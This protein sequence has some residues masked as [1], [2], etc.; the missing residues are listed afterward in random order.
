MEPSYGA[1]MRLRLIACCSVLLAASACGNSMDVKGTLTLSGGPRD[2]HTLTEDP[3]S[4]DPCEG[5]SGYS[6]IAEGTAVVV[7]NSKGDKI[8][9]SSLKA[10]KIKDGACVFPFE[11]SD[12]KGSGKIF[13]VEVAHRGEVSFKKSEATSLELSL[14]G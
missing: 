9:L 1:D 7:R 2:L 10:G 6:D 4:G 12:A 8:G 5:D 14:G 3:A 11:V 13:S